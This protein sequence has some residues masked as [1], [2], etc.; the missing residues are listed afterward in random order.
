MKILLFA[1]EELLHQKTYIKFMHWET[2]SCSRRSQDLN[3]ENLK[4]IGKS[5]LV[6]NPKKKSQIEK[7][8]KQ[9][10]KQTFQ[11]TYIHVFGGRTWENCFL[12]GDD[13]G[14]RNQPFH[15][16]W[17]NNLWD[18][19]EFAPQRIGR[20]LS[21]CP[22]QHQPKPTSSTKLFLPSKLVCRSKYHNNN[23]NKNSKFQKS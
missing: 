12:V 13:D 1:K 5:Q 15:G 16:W 10:N 22:F 6:I 4:T 20:P 19:H 17:S 23:N 2:F 11:G 21:L 9:T 8:T 14:Q 7:K 18:Y 3:L